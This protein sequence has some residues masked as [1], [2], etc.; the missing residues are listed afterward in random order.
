MKKFVCALLAMVMLLS[1][2][3]TASAVSDGFMIYGVPCQA[4]AD[5]QIYRY[6]GEKYVLKESN[7]HIVQIKH[8]V[9][10]TSAVENNRMAA[11]RQDNGKSMGAGWKPADNAYYPINSNAIV[12]GYRYTGA[13]RGNTNYTSKYGLNSITISGRIESYDD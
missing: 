7:N 13:A 3:A 12:K 2:A 5:D 9:T 1:L 4:I 6:H 11:Y 8:Y 10:Q